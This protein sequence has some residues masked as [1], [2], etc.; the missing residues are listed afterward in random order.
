MKLIEK[1]FPLKEVNLISEYEMSFL[2]MIPRDL[3]EALRKLYNLPEP[4]GRNLPK[5]SNIMYYPARIPPSAT[6]AV[7]LAS[8]L[9]Y[10]PAVSRE[11]FLRAV[12]LDNARELAKKSGALVTLYMADPDRG[13]VKRLLGKDPREITVVDP[14]AG[15]GS[16]PLESLR[17]GF[18]TIAGDLN[19]VSYLIL[20]ATI[21][22]PAKYGRKLLKLVEEEFRMLKEY[23]ERELGRFYGEEDKGYIYF[24]TAEHDCGGT[25]PL[26]MHPVLSRS[27]HIYVKPVFN[28]ESKSVSFEITTEITSFSPALCPYC[29]KPLGEEYIRMKWVKKH[30]E[31]LSELLNGNEERAEEARKTYVIAAVQKARE[32][33]SPPSELDA[34]RLVDAAKELARCAREE[35]SRG[36]SIRRYLPVSEIPQDNEVFSELRKYG[37]KYWYQLFTPRE[38]LALYK[39]TK[40]V[41]ERARQLHEQYGEL[42]D[43]VALYMAIALAKIMNF[44]NILS[45]WDP[46]DGTVRDL[47][48]GQYALTRGVELGSDY[49]EGSIPFKAI[50]WALE[51]EEGEAEEEAEE[52]ESTR[53]G[54][55]PVLR[56]LC[57]R[58]E[59]LWKDG[60]DAV[61]LWDAREIDKHLPEKSVDVV[62]VDPPY[63]DQHDYSGISEFFWVIIQKA[64]WPVLRGLFPGDRVKLEGWGPESPELPRH[65][66]IRGAPPK[67]VGEVSEFGGSFKRFLEAASGILKDDGLL[68]VWYAYGKLH[69]W[70]ELFYRL[71]EAGYGVTKTWQ[72]WTQSGQ[73][74][75]ALHTSAFFTSIVIVA[76]PRVKRTQ[77]VSYED[78][79]FKDDV[80]RSVESVASFVLGTYG[81][82]A[83]RE[84]TVVSI[85]DGFATATRYS[86]IGASGWLGVYQNLASIALREAVYAFLEYL[87]KREGIS[88]L[89][90]RGLD[91]VSRLY[92]F[93]LVASEKDRNSPALVVS[94]DF[95]N[96]VSQ[97]VRV[98][99]AIVKELK[100]GGSGKG[101]VKLRS[102]TEV[103]KK[104]P[105]TVIG[106]SIT[107]VEQVRKTMRE[108]GVRAAEDIVLKSDRSTVDL[109]RLLA[110][111][112]WDKLN[113][114]PDEKDVL[115]K[116]LSTGTGE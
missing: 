28:K 105:E 82:D 68:V 54:I 69:G 35:M 74:R 85:A 80:R 107:L 15:G 67:K 22:F 19:P 90:V 66:E 11:V 4:K 29:G 43:A 97:A 47:V 65:A 40:Y 27:R 58:L 75:I 104:Y 83:L 24:I 108:L 23:T 17:L 13:L 86:Y 3:K 94:S 77:I 110:A 113:I 81:L 1:E 64:V 39:L 101:T 12:G 99:E 18:R 42:G 53:G 87:A 112:S 61:Y 96:R 37:I 109:A 78:N 98:D 20:R 5:I 70:E 45:Q 63:Y 33:Y 73:R 93:L 60:L 51:V 30:T 14:M 34:A 71:Y 55:L 2:K 8:A 49:A 116:V 84:A 41:R 95:V 76:R 91:S 9:N 32:R 16:I 10:D 21:E 36:D 44:N 103:A 59:G 72:V 46:G 89:D 7:T 6:R 50:P 26:A 38:L 111:Y 114:P 88:R 25:I 100:I 106:E 92:T 31:I 62:D 48:G 52:V 102:P 79:M 57:N 56:L 115:L